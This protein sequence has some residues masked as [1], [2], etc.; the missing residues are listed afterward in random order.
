MEG[1]VN[2]GRWNKKAP[3]GTTLFLMC[4]LIPTLALLQSC[5][6]GDYL[7]EKG[8]CCNKCSPGFKLA[9]ECHAA[10]QRSNCTL[11]PDG[12][13]T[14]EMNYQI[15]CRRCRRCR[16]KHE[17]VKSNCEKN[18][19]TICRC[20]EGYYKFDIDSETYECRK[21]S[22][23]RPDEKKKETCTPEKNTVCECQENYYRVKSKC[24]P[25]KNCTT[26]CK[27]HC[28]PPLMTTRDPGEKENLII[29]IAGIAAVALVLVVLLVVI[30]YM[31]TKRSIKKEL[32]KSSSQP[33]DSSPDTCEVLINSEE[34]SNNISVKAA[35]QSPVSEQDQLSNLP[36]CVPLEIKIPDL[37]YTVLDLVPV[38]QV[39]QLVRFLGVKDTDI[40]QAELD[41]RSC[42]EAHYQMLRVWAERGSHTGGE[43]RGRMLHWPL[44]QE[45]MDKLRKM[46]LG[47]AAEE[48]ETK[49]NIQ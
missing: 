46:H 10:Q 20:V 38:L 24:E 17:V 21:C 12:E 5:P 29:I 39:K 47:R 3:V 35:P 34:P 18:Q 1:G 2:R 45:L 32:L 43:G 8:I 26:E 23:C 41:H 27:H 40:E 31:A 25:C 15:N 14:D 9:E 6:H 37:I 7:S 13:Y 36:D 33:S 22:Q 42:R 28:A 30:T 44:L 16:K 49:Y 48:L 19:N 11:C 4:M